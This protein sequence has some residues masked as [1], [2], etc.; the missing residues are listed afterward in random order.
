MARRALVLG[1]GSRMPPCAEGYDDVLRIDSNEAHKPDVVWD[2]EDLPLPL[3]DDSFD[4]IVAIE[5]LEHTG[6]QGDY[7]FFFEQF[8]DFYRILKRGGRLF[9][10][11]PAW[12]SLWA[13]GDPSHRRV[14]NEGTLS[15]L[16]QAEYA[17]QVGKTPMSDFRHI[18]QADFVVLQCG[19][20]DQVFMFELQAIKPSRYVE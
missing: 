7:E 15:F 5:V 19:Y 11:V 16:S 12:N 6:A 1:C 2:L 18:Y 20:K 8:S 9:A 13:W 17:A 3:D 10:E 14:I 4:L